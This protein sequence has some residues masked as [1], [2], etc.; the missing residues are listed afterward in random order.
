MRSVR[1]K[2]G[3]KYSDYVKPMLAQLHDRPFDDDEWL[4]EIKWDGYRAVAEV[5]KTIR[6]YSRNGLSF[7]DLYPVI[8]NALKKIKEKVILDGEIVA[9]NEKN[10]PDFQKLQQYGH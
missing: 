8:G 1:S 9:F 3:I 4:F 10:Q 7:L 2:G 6:L 5:Q